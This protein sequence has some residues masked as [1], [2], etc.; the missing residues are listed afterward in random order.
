MADRKVKSSGKVTS[1]RARMKAKP[2]FSSSDFPVIGVGASAGGLEA[3]GKLVSNIPEDSGMAFV[4]IQHLDPTHASNMVELP[5]R[6]TRIPVHEATDDIKLEPDHIYMIPPNRSMTITDRTLKLMEQVERSGIMHSIDH[7]FRSLAKDLKERAICIILS[8]TGTDG[9]MGAKA[10]KSEL[11]MVMV[12]DPETAAYDGMPRAAI[13]AGVAD[14]VLKAED[15]PEHLI[16]YV[17]KSYGKRIFRRREVEKDSA[18]LS[19]IMAL[20]RARTKHDF[21]GYK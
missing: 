14:F 20:I 16:E 18:S 9:S 3:F 5:K 7:F 1:P 12:Q 2:T 13:N 19:S 8:G 4:L 15:M 11:G 17:E 6:Y 21:S 10:V